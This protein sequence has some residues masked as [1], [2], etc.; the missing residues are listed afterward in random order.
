MVKHVTSAQVGLLL[1]R[2]QL[3]QCIL[4]LQKQHPCE[5][6]QLGLLQRN[7]PLAVYRV[8]LDALQDS[9]TVDWVSRELKTLEEEGVQ[10][11]EAFQRSQVVLQDTP[12]QC[13]CTGGNTGLFRTSRYPLWLLSGACAIGGLHSPSGGRDSGRGPCAMHTL[14]SLKQ[15]QCT[16]GWSSWNARTQG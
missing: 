12:L 10:G 6:L 16:R 13:E 7:W 1:G 14:R 8:P 5:P 3:E 4:Q 11:L 15:C 9:D 2:N